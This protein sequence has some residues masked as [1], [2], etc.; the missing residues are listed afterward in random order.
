[1]PATL[2]EEKEAIDILIGLAEKETSVA[3][4]AKWRQPV[5]LAP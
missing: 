5:A 3:A 1:L 2:T 4:A